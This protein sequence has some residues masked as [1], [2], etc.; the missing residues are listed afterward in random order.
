VYIYIYLLARFF[1]GKLFCVPILFI[2]KR[3]GAKRTTTPDTHTHLHTHTHT[4]SHALARTGKEEKKRESK[5]KNGGGGA[6]DTRHAR[7]KQ[8][9]FSFIVLSVER[10]A[11]SLSL[12]LHSRVIGHGEE[13]EGLLFRREDENVSAR[14]LQTNADAETF[15]RDFIVGRPRRRREE[16][17]DV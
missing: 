8:K 15:E 5:N 7:A 12:S 14:V 2:K 4:H 17:D 16:E 11:L 9:Q 1:L 6:R 10:H 3:A 13:E